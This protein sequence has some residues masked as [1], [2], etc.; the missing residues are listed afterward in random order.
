MIDEDYKDYNQDYKIP[1]V[2][3]MRVNLL[4]F[5]INSNSQN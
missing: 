4:S 3:Y 2:L 5:T 1:M